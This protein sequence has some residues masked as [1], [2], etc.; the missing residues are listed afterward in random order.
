MGSTCNA[1]MGC[2]ESQD[3]H[4]ESDK[5]VGSDKSGNK[6]SSGG[7]S[8]PATGKV[9]SDEVKALFEQVGRGNDGKIDGKVQALY[10]SQ[11]IEWYGRVEPTTDDH[12]KS[13]QKQRVESQF[14]AMGGAMAATKVSYSDWVKWC[15]EEREKLGR[16]SSEFGLTL[17]TSDSPSNFIGL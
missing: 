14:Q 17:G 15:H 9:S 12:Q 7:S 1:N 11:F 3:S 6:S 4:Q 5:K 10:K 2:A 8:K 16:T 13:A